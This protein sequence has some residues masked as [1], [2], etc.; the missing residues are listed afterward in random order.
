MARDNRITLPSS[1]AGLTR[2]FDDSKSKL[3]FSPQVVVIGI[4][5]VVIALLLLSGI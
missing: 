4:L 5:V 3:M 2:Y 1:G